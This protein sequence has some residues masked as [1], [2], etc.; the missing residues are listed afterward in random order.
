MLRQQAT[1]VRAPL[2]RPLEHL[3]ASTQVGSYTTTSRGSGSSP[4]ALR[5]L[6][7]ERILGTSLLLL[8]AGHSMK[9][10]IRRCNPL[11]HRQGQP[12]Q[13]EFGRTAEWLVELREPASLLLFE[14]S[15]FFLKHGLPCRW[16]ESV[17]SR[18]VV[19][20]QNSTVPLF[21][22]QLHARG[23]TGTAVLQRTF[24]L[25]IRCKHRES[26]SSP[27]SLS[28]LPSSSSSIELNIDRVVGCPPTRDYGVLDCEKFM[29]GKNR[30]KRSA[31]VDLSEAG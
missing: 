20:H 9:F 10:T 25:E 26:R 6:G 16:S 30:K 27:A 2:V 4:Y 31:T 17:L 15:R 19:K 24:P 13:E 7:H 18:V 23:L 21:Y 22:S 11:E 5:P 1:R 28:S 3:S 12:A 14:Q 29:V 8:D